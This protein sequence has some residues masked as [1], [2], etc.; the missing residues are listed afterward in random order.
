M[1]AEISGRDISIGSI[2]SCN[3]ERELLEDQTKTKPL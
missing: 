3:I 1:E 2:K